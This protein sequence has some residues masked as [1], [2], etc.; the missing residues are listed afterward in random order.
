MREQR[1]T[2]N[3][4][5]LF[6]FFTVSIIIKILVEKQCYQQQ[7][8]NNRDD[9]DCGR[10]PIRKEHF[11]DAFVESKADNEYDEDKRGS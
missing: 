5:E 6:S 1:E 9:E 4:V 3:L 8:G 2:A 11:H 7:A 10:H